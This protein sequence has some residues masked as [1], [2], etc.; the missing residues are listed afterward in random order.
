[1]WDFNSD[2]VTQNITL[3]AKWIE[4]F[5]VTFNANGGTP[6][7]VQQIIASGGKA[8]NP[9]GMRKEG[10]NFEGWYK[11]AAFNNLWDFD[12]DIVT[13]NLELY[14]KWG[15]PIIV[16]GVSLAQKLQWLNSNAI[17][18]TS[19]ILEV[20]VNET[21]SSQSCNFSY[22][23]KSNI[24][25]QLR[26][27]DNE[28]VIN[29]SGF[30]IGNGVTLIIDNNITLSSGIA[31]S[32]NLIINQGAVITGT[33]SVNVNGTFTMNGGKISGVL[34]YVSGTFTMSGGEISD[35]TSGLGG[36]VYVSGTF[37]MSGGEI[38]GNTSGHG[39]GVSV[40]GGGTFTMYGGEISGNNTGHG[41]GVSVSGGGTFTMS[42]GEI[43]GNTSGS[44]GGT[45]FT[46][47][48]GEISGNNTSG[49]G[50][51]VYLIRNN[52]GNFIKSGG[53]IK[54]YSSDIA[55]GNVVKNDS[56]VIQNDQGHAVY[57]DHSDSRYIKRKETT[58]GTNDNLTY[59]GNKSNPLD[60]PT[61]SGQWDY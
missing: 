14:A 39:G 32:G 33:R 31:S 56:G 22:S 11:E 16:S 5:T 43:S 34:V 50:G 1:L 55:N 17:S 3:Y 60:P 27:I 25:I 51:G 53:I 44:G 6:V 57:A 15:L 7:P 61:W 24:T 46:M 41:G 9:Q 40:S 19:Y 49:S 38:S 8:S 36:G 13:G 35:N 4:N 48:G 42:G 18:N 54:G 58:A 2:I 52:S 26:G 47:Y 12:N 21:L 10:F 20:D 23:G 45:S 59:I 30:T 28:K 37:T 29:G